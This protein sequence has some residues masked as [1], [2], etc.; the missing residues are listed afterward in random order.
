MSFI[1]YTELTI[2]L[3]FSLHRTSRCGPIIP[4][5]CWVH[6]PQC[7]PSPPSL[8]F[9]VHFTRLS[10]PIT[11]RSPP[12]SY[13]NILLSSIKHNAWSIMLQILLLTSPLHTFPSLLGSSGGRE[14][15]GSTVRHPSSPSTCPASFIL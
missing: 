12:M 15:C 6:R 9:T 2:Y 11:S 4:S 10:Y 1:S 5:M 7:S 8:T 3:Y 13:Q 14:L